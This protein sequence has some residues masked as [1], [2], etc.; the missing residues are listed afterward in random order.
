LQP[1]LIRHEQMK[2][3]EHRSQKSKLMLMPSQLGT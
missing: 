1:I 3:L 2:P